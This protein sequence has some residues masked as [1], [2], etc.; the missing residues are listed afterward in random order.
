MSIVVPDSVEDDVESKGPEL[1][2][3]CPEVVHHRS[4]ILH[5]EDE[6]VLGDHDHVEQDASR[7]WMRTPS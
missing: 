3:Q 6:N 2:E 5:P 1:D 4:G 7:C